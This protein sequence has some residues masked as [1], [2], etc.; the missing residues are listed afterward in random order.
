[1]N[2]L[3]TSHYKI[4]ISSNCTGLKLY[5]IRISRIIFDKDTLISQQNL[6]I[7][8]GFKESFNGIT[9]PYSIYTSDFYARN[10]VMG[11]KSFK[12]YNLL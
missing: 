11:M 8:S 4:I 9:T 6:Y 3:N 12:F 10:F 1:M 7:D 2:I 5:N